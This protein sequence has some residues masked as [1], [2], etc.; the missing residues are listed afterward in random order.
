MATFTFF[1][2]F[3]GNLGLKLIDLEVDVIKAALTNIAP[4]A[5]TDDEL[6]DI[7]QIAAGNGYLA[8]GVDVTGTWA[9]TGAGTGVWRFTGTDFSWTASGGDIATFRYVVVYSDTSVGDKL[10]G[11][12]DVGAATT[13]TNGN[14]FLV[15]I[16]ASGFFELS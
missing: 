2:E 13:I 9:E 15:D 6:A 5:G 11:Y 3:K 12:L 4:V 16:G 1:H 10:I 8:G 14:T 7:T